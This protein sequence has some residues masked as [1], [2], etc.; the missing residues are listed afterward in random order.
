VELRRARLSARILLQGLRR[1]VLRNEDAP[2]PHVK[3]AELYDEALARYEIHPY[4]GELT[5]FLAQRHLAGMDDPL[6]GWNGIAQAGLNLYTLPISPRGSLVEPYARQLAAH[7]RACIDRAIA[8]SE[9]SA[10]DSEDLL[11]GQRS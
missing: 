2:L 6:G 9:P 11:A 5:L 4:P 1:R 8:T 7:L 10:S 3:L